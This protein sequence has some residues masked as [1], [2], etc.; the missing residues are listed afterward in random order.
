MSRGTVGG[1]AAP[2]VQIGLGAGVPGPVACRGPRRL[3]GS[4]SRGAP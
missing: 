4:V 2:L 3:L 1:G